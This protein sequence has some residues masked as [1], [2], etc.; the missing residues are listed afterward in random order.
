M[1]CMKVKFGRELWWILNLTI[2][3]VGGVLMQ[4][5]DLMGWVYGRILVGVGKWFLII[6][7]LRLEI[8]PRL[9]FWHDLWCKH[10]A[11]KEAFLDLSSN[12]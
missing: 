10:M 11:I 4:L 3:G 9:D 7:D 8:A 2:Q 1:A 12:A 6:P 5:L